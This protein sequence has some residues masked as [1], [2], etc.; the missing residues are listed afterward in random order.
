MDEG[1]SSLKEKF[2]QSVDFAFFKR[3]KI[4]HNNCGVKAVLKYLN[5]ICLLF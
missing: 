2:V 4:H 5:I 1:N 3:L